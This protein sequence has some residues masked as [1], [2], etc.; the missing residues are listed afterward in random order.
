ME[1]VC[2]ISPVVKKMVVDWEEPLVETDNE[3][4]VDDDVDVAVLCMMFEHFSG[5]NIR[6]LYWSRCKHCVSWSSKLTH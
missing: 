4:S 6:P 5:F 3:L 2:F 1:F